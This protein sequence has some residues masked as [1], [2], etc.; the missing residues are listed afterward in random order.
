MV[1]LSSVMK[2]VKRVLHTAMIGSAIAYCIVINKERWL[3]LSS[4]SPILAVCR[5]RVTY[6]PSHAVNALARY[7]FS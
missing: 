1:I 6:E 2:Y 5:A 7:E 3:S 4:T